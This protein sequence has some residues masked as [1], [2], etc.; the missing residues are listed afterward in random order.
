M[1]EIALTVDNV[2]KRFCVARVRDGAHDPR[3]ERLSWRHDLFWALR[4][5]SFQVERG[6]TLGLVGLNGSGK[7][8]LLKILCGVMTPDAGRIEAQGRIG[9]LLELGAGF[10][11]ELS[12]LENVYLNGALLGLDT[13]E[14]DRLLPEI[15]AF[16]ELER[17]MDMPIKRYSSGM[18]ARLGFAVATRLAPEILLMDET[19]A[20]GDA[21][22]Q[23]KAL[24]HVAQM[25]A[26]GHTMLVVSHNLEIMI[27]LADDVL[28]IDHGRVRMH[29]PARDVLSEYRR[30]RIDSFS[31]ERMR[32]SLGLHSIFDETDPERGVVR[33]AQA[34]WRR[35]AGDGGGEAVG[36]ELGGTLLLDLVLAHPG[37]HPAR[38]GVETAWARQGDNKVMAQSR[39]VV[40]LAP[41]AETRCTV[42]LGP[43]DLTEGAWRC[44][45]ALGAASAEEAPRGFRYYDRLA[46]AGQV[47][48]LTPNAIELEVVTPIRTRWTVSE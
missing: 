41:G 30:S 24:D 13:R 18:T 23:A 9:A 14:V 33:I 27:D 15:I 20:T 6:R 17:F 4:D 2:S 12:G 48:T 32:P 1:S 10:H 43:W 34:R 22:F 46:E 38:V 45:L 19:F 21:R 35:E 39:A 3:R 5:V 8:T 29:G 36:L 44:V 42:R 28:W 31:A 40:A 37:A 26:R 16:A 47:R 25:R 7:S 11:P